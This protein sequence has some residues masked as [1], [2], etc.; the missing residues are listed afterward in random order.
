MEEAENI[1]FMYLNFILWLK[2]ININNII[3]QNK[4]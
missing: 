2:I 1:K 4:K 3:K